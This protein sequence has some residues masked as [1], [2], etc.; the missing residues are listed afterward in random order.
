MSDATLQ[1]F[2][3]ALRSAVVTQALLLGALLW[4]DHRSAAGGWLAALFT[5]GIA[6]YALSTLPGT[7]PGAA[8]G[9]W[10]APF[11][12]LATGNAVVFW[13]FARVLF[14]DNFRLQRWHGALWALFAGAGFANCLWWASPGLGRVISAATLAFAVLAAAQT[15]QT[16][17]ADLL[18]R[19]R[20]LRLFIVGAGAAYTV[21]TAL[22]R[23]VGVAAG[24]FEMLV[25]ALI[26]AIAAW[27]LLGG[28]G[29]FDEAPA[30]AAPPAAAPVAGDPAADPAADAAA[31]AADARLAA[32][33]EHAMTQQHVYREEALS[34]GALASRLGAPEYRLRRL[35]NQ[36]LGHRNFNAYLNR[37][38][39]DEAK[40]AL[41]DPATAERPVLVI[42]LD[43]GFQSVGPFNRAFK[44][45][46]GVTPTE[47]R[48]L[49]LR[50]S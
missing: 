31:D 7:A 8:P 43:A 29:L 50:D 11:T 19:R 34:I 5:A 6:G 28:A 24:A 12:A 38:R 22:A 16:W 20:A 33:L 9:A 36:Q 40:R 15:L 35:I 37:Y 25:L 44:A 39:L 42:A 1:T 18:E 27:R 32:A 14:D 45:D 17:R 30:S 49:S 23:L 10:L 3:I 4:R 41:T 26:L 2:D 47:F 13:L 46:T 48:R 21:A